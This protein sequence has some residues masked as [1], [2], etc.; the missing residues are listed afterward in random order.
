MSDVEVF[1]EQHKNIDSFWLVFI[2][3]KIA[4]MPFLAS[5]IPVLWH[6]YA[7]LLLIGLLTSVNTAQKNN[8]SQGKE[9]INYFFQHLSFIKKPIEGFRPR[10]VPNSCS[11]ALV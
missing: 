5:S 9:I 6:T 4:M 8:P 3:P 10:N 1:I 7:T 11:K 2:M